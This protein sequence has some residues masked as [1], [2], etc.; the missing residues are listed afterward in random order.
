VRFGTETT[1][2]DREGA[3]TRTADVP[4][5]DMKALEPALEGLR[6]VISQVPPRFAAL[7]IRG[8]PA[9]ARAR[10][11][12]EVTLAARPVQVHR[13]EVIALEPPELRLLVVCSS[14]TYIRALARDLGRSLGTAAHLSGLRRLAVGAL[15]VSHALLATELRD[16]GADRLVARLLPADDSVLP[17]DRRY[18]ESPG[19]IALA[20]DALR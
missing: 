10:K 13:L 19:T 9:Y 2:D 11:G 3:V 15:D 1:T 20:G 16:L 17:L 6:G 18:L 4:A 7:K 12:E 14:G 5:L 8:R